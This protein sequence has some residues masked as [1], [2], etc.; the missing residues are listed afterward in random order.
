[1]NKKIIYWNRF[2]YEFFKILIQHTSGYRAYRERKFVS[3]KTWWQ[4]FL[5]ETTAWRQLPF[6]QTETKHGGDGGGGGGHVFM[7]DKLCDIHKQMYI[8]I[9][10]YYSSGF[11]QVTNLWKNKNQ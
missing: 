2:F 5:T 9:T 7:H 1:M 11:N 10:W 6:K 4:T 3:S 8:I